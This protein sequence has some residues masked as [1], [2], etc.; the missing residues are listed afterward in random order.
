MKTRISK[1]LSLV[2]AMAL[3]LSLCGLSA[4][5]TG[6]AASGTCGDDLTWTLTEDGVLTISGTGA[7]E[8]Y[9]NSSTPWS[10]Y[11]NDILKVVLD[12][13]I[14]TIGAGAFLDCENLTSITIPNSVTTIGVWAFMDCYSLTDV[15]ILGSVTAIGDYMFW[16]CT[17]LTSVTIPDSVTTIGQS[18]FSNCTSLAS[19]NIPD[20]VTTIG[21]S[22]FFACGLTSITIPASVTSI[23]LTV[24]T[25][26]YNLTEI[27]VSP[28]NKNYASVDGVLYNKDVTELVY[29]PAGKT[30][31]MV[32]IPNG[33]TT[34]GKYSFY[35]CNIPTS[36]TIPASVTSIGGGAFV[37]CDSLTS[38]TFE[39]SAPSFSSFDSIF[40]GC[41]LT[42]Y[43][44]ADDSSW[45]EDVMQ[46]YGGTVTWVAY[47]K[48]TDDGDDDGDTPVI[49]DT[50][51]DTSYTIGSG[52]CASIHCSGELADLI[53]VA[54][55]GK[56]VDAS[57]YDLTE[58]STI[59]TFHSDFL[60]SLAPGDHEV[61]LTFTTGTAT[62]TITVLSVP[63]TD[64]TTPT[65]NGD[66][67]TGDTTTEDEG[68]ADHAQPMLWA[69]V[70]LVS[71]TGLGAMVL[72][73]KRTR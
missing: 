4:F 23:S 30:G 69:A 42:A 41:T 70:L 6:A 28:D 63:T 48:N 58:G 13:N 45:T 33:V 21:A 1:L 7:M 53:S 2:L 38:V 66:S 68:L 64:E 65:D 56:T 9:E 54:V 47:E 24:F 22:A 51:T 55:D 43:Y 39:G 3:V 8:D 15:T 60:D 27:V 72:L 12:G 52:A 11:R 20:S 61:T 46:D 73:K 34:I 49:L 19:I 17:S 67:T 29:Y 31:A 57:S 5:A 71:M 32:E 40:S 50:A 44:P 18:A 37:A 35:A 16:N 14:T 36:I 62:A 59:V 25:A 10:D 26:C